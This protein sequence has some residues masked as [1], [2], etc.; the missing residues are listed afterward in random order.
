M[1]LMAR[2]SHATPVGP[3]AASTLRRAL[4]WLRRGRGDDITAFRHV[5]YQ[6]T[7]GSA[8]GGASLPGE[9]LIRITLEVS[10]VTGRP[11]GPTD[12]AVFRNMDSFTPTQREQ[13]VRALFRS[14]APL[15]RGSLEEL[16]RAG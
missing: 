7:L 12:D 10:C 2:V 8:A 1:D 5:I 16:R 4:H 3:R 6:P 13:I 11:G 14:A 9:G 15:L